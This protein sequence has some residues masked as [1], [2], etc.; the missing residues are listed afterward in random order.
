MFYLLIYIY[1]FNYCKNLLVITIG[2]STV[3][4]GELL[5]LKSKRYDRQ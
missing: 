1:P 5:Y 2:Q 3:E 4:N